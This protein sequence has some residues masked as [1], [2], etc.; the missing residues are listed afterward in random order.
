MSFEFLKTPSVQL[1]GG[2]LVVTL[3]LDILIRRIL[4]RTVI[5]KEAENAGTPEAPAWRHWLQAVSAPLSLLVWYYGVYATARILLDYLLP[6]RFDW[7][8]DWLG[9]LSGAGAFIGIVWLLYRVARV[10]ETHLRTAATASPGR[11][12]DVLL[13]LIGAALRVLVPVTA[14][15]FLVRLWP[16]ESHTLQTINKLIAVVFITAF[17]WLVLQAVKLTERTL[18]SSQ[19]LRATANYNGRAFVTRVSVLRKILMVLIVVFALSAILMLFEEVRDVGRSILASAGVAGIILGFAAQRS[20]GGLFA[21]LQIALT[22]PIRLGDQVKVEDVVGIVEEI[23]LTFVV[24]RIWDQRRMIVP[25]SFFIENS[26]INYTRTSSAQTGFVLLRADFT[27][28]VPEFRTYIEGLVKKSPAWDK[29][30]FAVQ[31]TDARHESM[32]LRVICGAENP[33]DAFNLQCEVREA[34][35]DFIHRRYPQCLPKAREEGKPIK[36]WTVSEELLPRDYEMTRVA[37]I[38]AAAKP[39]ETQSTP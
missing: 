32:E 35:L 29:K 3:L 26:V 6:P 20:L 27:L 36:G 7:I 15:F 23:T 19:E 37:A 28:P 17:A 18:T 34:A 24:L 33:G 12:D 10:I 21:G 4:G 5:E 1:A 25:I 9:N 8:D 2:L 13:P 39:E 22:Q 38:A 11:L 31:V 14:L 30:N 16:L